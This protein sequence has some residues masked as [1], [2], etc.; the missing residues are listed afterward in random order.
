MPDPTESIKQAYERIQV[1]SVDFEATQPRKKKIL[2]ISDHPLIPSGVGLQS[3]Y[4]IEALL[5]TGKYKVVSWGAAM[6]HPDHRP[7]NVF[8]E[9]YGGDWIVH[10]ID[11]YGDRDRMRAAILNEKPDALFIVTDP[12]FYGW[13]F[14]MADEIKQNMPI[15]YWH[16]WDNDP[17]PD[18]ND[19]YY[20]CIDYLVPLSLKTH[21]LIQGMERASRF[22]GVYKYVPHAIPPD[23]FK[24]MPE[25]D[26]VRFRKARLGPHWDKK[27]VVFWNNRNARRKMSGDVVVV[28]SKLADQI[29]RENCILFM[30][31]QPRDPEGQDL[32]AV[33][34]QFNVEKNLIMSEAR[35]SAQDMCMFYNCADATLNIANNE[36]FGLGTLESLMCGT[37]IVVHMTG[38]LQFQ[39]GNWWAGRKDFSDQDDLTAVAKRKWARR[40]GRWFGVPVFSAS[41]S[42]TGSQPV[43]YIYDDRVSH[44]DVVRALRS[45]YDL[46]R[47]MRRELGQQGRAW[48]MEAFSWNN[49]QTAWPSI[50]D[51]AIA[52][53]KKPGPRIIT[54]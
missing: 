13:L 53:H 41:R 35:V 16:V 29:G 30:Q 45:L 5:K 40:E 25:D 50:I 20:E 28:F 36:G 23:Q 10:P 19:A 54:L 22:K 6:T 4:V 17:I 14:E 39:I 42:C 11:G 33:A 48:A 37:P 27:F 44:E 51:Q 46:G 24:V 47:P 34:R 8:P 52:D 43:P 2:T 15:V 1:Q 31:T 26:I 9:L 3:R 21:G 7:Q 38:G 18:F 12:R 32:F 49:L